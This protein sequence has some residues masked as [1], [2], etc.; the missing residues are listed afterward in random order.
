[1]SGD[2]ERA[3]QAI[4]RAERVAVVAH[5]RPDGD[6]VGSLLG[7][8]RSLLL[9]GKQAT[10]VLS[11][12]LPA[13]FHFLP[14]AAAVSRSLP[15]PLDLLI[16]VDCSTLDRLGFPAERLPRRPDLNLDHH[17][18]NERFAAVNLVDAAAAST[19]Q[20]IYELA[21]A[22]GLPVDARV[23]EYLLLGLVT[24]TIGFRTANVRPRVLR[25]AAELMEKGARLAEVYEKALNRRSLEAARYWGIGLSRLQMEDGLLWTWLTLEDRQAAGYPGNDDAELVNF[26]TTIEGAN[27]VVLFVEQPGGR[28]KVSWRAREGINVAAIAAGFG[29]GGHEPAAGAMLEGSLEE[30]RPRVLQATRRAMHPILEAET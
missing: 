17:P 12:G 29:G 5:V 18:T 21:P 13:H 25:L 7:L 8:W 3:R 1:M 23:A 27:V 20:V 4:Q 26:L 10:P 9:L 14:D 22:L 6:A 16:A 24:D 2:L 11:E 28:V 15:D 19:T 30:V